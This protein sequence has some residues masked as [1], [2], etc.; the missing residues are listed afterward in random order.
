[1]I[2]SRVIC[3]SLRRSN[4]FTWE[5]SRVR[6]ALRPPT[7][8]PTP[9]ASLGLAKPSRDGAP[10]AKPA[11]SPRELPRRA[12]GPAEAGGEIVGFVSGVVT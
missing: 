1:M 2:T 6:S 3:R 5:P 10:P 9:L 7:P 8:S 11:G 12:A 4:Q